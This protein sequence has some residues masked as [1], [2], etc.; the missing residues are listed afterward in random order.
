VED[1]KDLGTTVSKKSY[2]H[3]D[4]SPMRPNELWTCP[5]DGAARAQAPGCQHSSCGSVWRGRAGDRYNQRRGA[6]QAEPWSRRAPLAVS[7]NLFG[8]LIIVFIH[9]FSGWAEFWKKMWLSRLNPK[10]RNFFE[11][12]EAVLTHS[13]KRVKGEDPATSESGYY[14]RSLDT[15]KPRDCNDSPISG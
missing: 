6:Q 13:Q 1:F 4:L 10:C 15:R 9:K 2:H 3:S 8:Q 5:D 7:Q 14:L 12:F 11:S